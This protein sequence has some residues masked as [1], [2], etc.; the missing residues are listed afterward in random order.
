MAA[1]ARFQ[2]FWLIAAAA[3]FAAAAAHVF[4][5]VAGDYLLAHDDYDDVAHHSRL[6]VLGLVAALAVVAAL[7][8]FGEILESKTR[9]PRTL[10]Y[11][12]RRSVG[13]PMLFCAQTSLLT[14][15]AMVAMEALDC[16]LSGGVKD[17][18]ALLGGSIPLGGGSAAAIGALFGSLAHRFVGWLADRE[19]EIAALIVAAFRVRIVRVGY[20]R[21]ATALPATPPLRR[22]LLLSCLGRKRGPPIPSPG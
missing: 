20:L 19:P 16:A 12:L 15:L 21:A 9:N 3:A 1:R 13:N 5:D 14:I 11:C 8:V 2:R 18:A 22:E 10:L 4:V 6:I 17:P 7:R